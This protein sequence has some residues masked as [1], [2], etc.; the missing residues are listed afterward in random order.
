[1][2]A[3]PAHR[4]KQRQAVLGAALSVV[5]LALVTSVGVWRWKADARHVS[6]DPV[7]LCPTKSGPLG[8]AA[9]LVDVSDSPNPVQRAALMKELIDLETEIAVHHRVR[10]YVLDSI[11]SKELP[12]PAFDRCKPPAPNDDLSELDNNLKLIGDRFRGNYLEPLERALAAAT[13][14]GPSEDSPIMEWI[15]AA[16]VAGFPAD[17][18]NT[19]RM[20]VVASDFL[21]H[22]KDY[23]HYGSGPPSF[24]RFKAS[25]TSQ[26]V[27]VDLSKF[28]V[29]L[30]YLRRDGQ[31]LV[32]TV[33]HK[34]FWKKFFVDS[35]VGAGR[36]QLTPIPG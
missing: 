29:R 5:A 28:D 10:V 30:F 13:S 2:T 4:R 34:E 24:D 11:P 7:S 20:L 22:T 16:A 27:R 3:S 19:P 23:S 15:Q 18:S 35:G 1:M 9:I 36:L 31:S 21:Q 12:K 8:Y 14:A 33:D 17:S 25:P 26:R 32:Q 6:L